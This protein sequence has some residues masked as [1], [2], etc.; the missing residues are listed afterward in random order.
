M[1]HSITKAGV[2]LFLMALAVTGDAC[3]QIVLDSTT[4]VDPRSLSFPLLVEHD[5][6]RELRLTPRDSLRLKFTILN[7]GS[8]PILLKYGSCSLKVSAIRIQNTDSLQARIQ[9]G[10]RFWDYP[11]A[12]GEVH[13]LQSPSPSTVCT[14]ELRT[15]SLPAGGTTALPWSAFPLPVG[16]YR[17]GVCLDL[18]EYPRRGEGGWQTVRWCAAQGSHVIVSPQ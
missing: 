2:A 10:E 6:P 12:W 3:A 5:L 11:G 9:R 15:L 4:V 8:S 14:A 1:S 13:Y 17:L 18:D 16:E 7:R